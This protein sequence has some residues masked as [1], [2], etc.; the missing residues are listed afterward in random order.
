LSGKARRILKPGHVFSRIHVDD[1][2]RALTVAVSKEKT[3][4]YNLADNHPAAST[5][6]IEYACKLLNVEPPSI[7]HFYE[8]ELSAMARS[9]YADNK[10]VNNRKL[11]REL[12]QYLQYPSYKEGLEALYR[13]NT[14]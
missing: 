5:E 7:E 4:V 2:C 10:R 11:L 6:V 13:E 14:T 3:G 8:A 1:I 9:F 12:V